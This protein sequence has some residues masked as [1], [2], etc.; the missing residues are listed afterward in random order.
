GC[1]GTTAGQAVTIPGA[2]R[3]PVAQSA[4]GQVKLIG[5]ALADVPLTPEQRADIEKLAADADVRH[6]GARAARKELMLAI[7]AQIEAGAIDRAGLQPRIDALVA[8]AG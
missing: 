8:A 1:G 5:E 7:A 3:A 4:H 6:E 2:V